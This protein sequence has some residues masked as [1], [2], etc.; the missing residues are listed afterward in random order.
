M[1]FNFVSN[2]KQC[3]Q[4]YLQF[5][6]Q[7]ETSQ[8]NRHTPI[9]ES[10]FNNKNK[11]IHS[12]CLGGGKMKFIVKKN[13]NKGG[14]TVCVP[15]SQACSLTCYETIVEANSELILLLCFFY[16]PMK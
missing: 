8:I 12:N 10:H 16:L 5:H 2:P 4:H 6:L 7:L 9:I 3:C 13:T 1:L 15:Y 11:K 14:N